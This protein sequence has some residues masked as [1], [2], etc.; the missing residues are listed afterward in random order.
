MTTT[1]LPAD[2]EESFDV[3]GAGL[4]GR[5]VASGISVEELQLAARN[6]GMPLEALRHDITPLGL[7]YLLVHYDIPVVDPRVVA[8]RPSAAASADRSS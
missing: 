8:A 3:H 7:H 4:Y 6:H 2:R 5:R 1:A